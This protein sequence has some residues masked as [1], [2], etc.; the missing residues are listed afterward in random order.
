MVRVREVAAAAWSGDAVKSDSKPWKPPKLYTLITLAYCAVSLCVGALALAAAAGWSCATFRT[1]EDPG[2][3]LSSLP[4]GMA[5]SDLPWDPNP[6]GNQHGMFNPTQYF[7]GSLDHAAEVRLRQGVNFPWR[8]KLER[9]ASGEL[10]L[11]L[12]IWRESSGGRELTMNSLFQ[13]GRVLRSA[14]MSA[15]RVW[16]VAH[17][18]SGV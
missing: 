4:W 12:A 17:G 14:L 2:C 1:C 15:A 3:T 5:E 6:N 8:P 7:F 9:S 18:C 16:M 13:V 11:T 10:L